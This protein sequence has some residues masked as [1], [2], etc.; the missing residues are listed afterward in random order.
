LETL[1]TASGAFSASLAGVLTAIFLR[2]P[3]GSPSLVRGWK[4][5]AVVAWGLGVLVGLAPLAG[6]LLEIAWLRTIQPAGLFA[7]L[8]SGVTLLVV[9]S[10]PRR[11]PMGSTS[12]KSV[13]STS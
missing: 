8:I 10:G 11:S 7:Y 3:G 6:E 12:A 9:P 13:E 1:A 4:W 5:P 2:H